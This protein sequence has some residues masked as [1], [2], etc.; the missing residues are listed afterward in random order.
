MG[1]SKDRGYCVAIMGAGGKTSL[2]FRM[3]VELSKRYSRVLL[4]S[5]TRSEY[6]AGLHT[7]LALETANLDL[8]LL[9]QTAN[10]LFLMGYRE[11]PAK[12]AGISVAELDAVRSQAD[13]CLFECDGARG[14]S[15]KAHIDSDPHVPP[16]ATHVII[17]VGADVA[18]TSPAQGH[19]HRPEVFQSLWGIDERTVLDAGFIAQVV[20]SPHGYGSK[21][22]EDTERIYYVNKVDT[23]PREAEQI[24]TAIRDLSGARTYTGSLQAGICYRIE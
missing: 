15:L 18:N 3:G 5:L 21:L 11:G 24:A 22:P 10:P 13:V 19:I 14:R 16:F 8:P 7:V 6:P 1:R 4:T 12:L 9:F 2:L 23:H 17:V 20:T